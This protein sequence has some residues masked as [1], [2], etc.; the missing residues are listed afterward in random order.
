MIWFDDATSFAD[1]LGLGWKR[2]GA[3]SQWPRTGGSET[4]PTFDTTH[5]DTDSGHNYY[6]II[7]EN[8]SN[9]VMKN[10]ANSVVTLLVNAF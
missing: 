6:G 10:R 2:S 3:G 4:T 1:G 7:C 8:S 9:G 5:N